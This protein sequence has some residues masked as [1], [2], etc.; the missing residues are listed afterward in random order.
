[1]HFITLYRLIPIENTWEISWGNLGVNLGVIIEFLHFGP[2]HMKE[3]VELRCLSY[4]TR[5]YLQCFVRH[6]TRELQ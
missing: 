1:M 2:I 6:S 5:H 3:L 4:Y